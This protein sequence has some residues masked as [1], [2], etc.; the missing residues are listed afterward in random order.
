MK[1]PT[2][3][4]AIALALSGAAN[5]QPGPLAPPAPRPVPINVSFD[6]VQDT[7]DSRFTSKGWA[8]LDTEIGY[9]S[10]FQGQPP[11]KVDFDHGEMAIAVY[12]GSEPTTGYSI[13]ITKIVQTSTPD[14]SGGPD[15]PVLTV[16][17]QR[18]QPGPFAIEGQIV[19]SPLEVVKF[20]RP[21]R[22][23]GSNV[24]FVD[25]APP[26]TEW[27]HFQLDEMSGWGFGHS[28]SLDASGAVTVTPAR[29]GG[30]Q[31][32]VSDQA[33]PDELAAVSAALPGADVANL[34]ATIPG[35][36]PDATHFTLQTTA[37]D[38]SS[39]QTMGFLAKLG[40]YDGQLRPL[41]A[42]LDAIADRVLNP[43]FTK[44]TY[45]LDTMM[46][47]RHQKLSVRSD[48]SLQLATQKALG[49]VTTISAQATPDELAALNTAF[50]AARL[51]ELDGQNLTNRIIPDAPT[52]TISAL[53]GTSMTTVKGGV[54]L[55][56]YQNRVGPVV[57]ALNAILTRLNANDRSLTGKVTA[58]DP[59][60]GQVTLS[61]YTPTK[62]TNIDYSLD[63]GNLFS[64]LS[65]NLG[66]QV[67]LEAT[68][69]GTSGSITR[70]T[71]QNQTGGPIEV[72]SDGTVD[73]DTVNEVPA[74]GKVAIKDVAYDFMGN[75]MYVI[76]TTDDHGNAMDGYIAASDV[77]V[78]APAFAQP[79]TRGLTGALTKQ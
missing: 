6:V 56:V 66:Q 74:N 17:V 43:S 76:D 23:F 39:Y 21:N 3:A 45:D 73:S 58:V 28:I 27:S 40:N 77:T 78:G 9:D 10:F 46:I 37:S 29:V 7:S 42:A 14:P 50:K 35:I 51:R 33:S 49:E 31:Q 18:T 57:K 53:V 19:T 8:I 12:M 13:G 15:L 20:L 25:V 32:P 36:V 5:A 71:A 61:V 70:V 75:P 38:G 72:L 64:V 59:I 48:G 68:L 34:P 79:R 69:N 11:A 24:H 4:I 65:D 26:V 63:P 47:T 2:P 54:D 44:L 60:T 67:T 16:S 55:G 62:G 52:W 41:L 30:N 22:L 1:N